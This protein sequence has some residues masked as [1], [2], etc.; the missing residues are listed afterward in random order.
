MVWRGPVAGA[1]DQLTEGRFR[2]S[3]LAWVRDGAPVQEPEMALE[4][5]RRRGPRMKAEW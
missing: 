4:F 3:R 2:C 5:N 1:A